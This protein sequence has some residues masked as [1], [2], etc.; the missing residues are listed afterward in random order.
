MAKTR[1][2]KQIEVVKELSGYSHCLISPAGV[3]HFCEPFGLKPNIAHY[4]ANPK[5]PKGLTL[6]DGAE[7]AEGS[8]A[9]Y[10]AMDICRHLG[11]KYMQKLGRGFQL[12]ECC[13]VLLDHLDT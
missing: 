3:R 11:L 12:H 5:D 9:E 6:N 2:T 13:R 8:P 4:K 7:E 10:V 1:R